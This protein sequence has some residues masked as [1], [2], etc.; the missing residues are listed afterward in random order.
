VSSTEIGI[1]EVEEAVDK[2]G[3]PEILHSDQ[4]SQF[5]SMAFSGLL[6][7]NGIAVRMEG[8]GAWRDNV[9]VERLWRPQSARKFT[10]PPITPSRTSEPRQI[11]GLL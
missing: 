2:Y 1:Q 5:T 10:C 4:G 8:R 6:R 3:A 7:D 9:F 11:S